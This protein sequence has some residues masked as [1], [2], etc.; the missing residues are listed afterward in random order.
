M[1]TSIIY[2]TPD[3]LAQI[4]A[5]A[6]AREVTTEQVANEWLMERVALDYPE[7]LKL[8]EE[9][10]KVI[11]KQYDDFKKQVEVVVKAKLNAPTPL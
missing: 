6:A 10:S 4:R 9:H 11:G 3:L 2:T 5:I 7:V 8:H 1:R